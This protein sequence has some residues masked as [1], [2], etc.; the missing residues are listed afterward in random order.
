MRL[1][2]DASNLRSGGGITHIAELLQAARPQEHG[3][4]KV[5]VW[6]GGDTLRQLPSLPW[7]EQVYEPMLDKSLPARLY[8]QKMKLPHL[9][10][11]SCDCLFVPGGR[12]GGGFRP[13]VTMS[14]N[15]LPFESKEW[16]R[17]G[18]S[19]MAAKMFLL[20]F[21]QIRSL[22]NADGVIFL[23]EYARSVVCRT[24]RLK[25]DHP[26]IRHGVNRRFF[27][28]PREQKPIEQY[29]QSRPFKLLYVSKVEPYKHQWSIVEAVSKLRWGGLPISLELV[30]EPECPMAMQL[31]NQAIRKADPCH[32]FIQHLGYM[33]HSSLPDCYHNAD[34]FI[35]ASSCENLPN[36]LLEAMASGL[37]IACSNH[38]PMPE[39]LG[40]A[41]VYFDPEWPE[42]VAAAIQVLVE[43]S[44][45]RRFFADSAYER[46]QEYSWERCA[47]ETFAYLSTLAGRQPHS[48]REALQP[49]IV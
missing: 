8:W 9:A 28:S 7:L 37:P 3:I 21:S 12:T 42:Q 40:E 27:L 4:A 35:F 25:R 13:F 11:Q 39:I 18:F 22:R 36:I 38:G 26:V 48:Y 19:W 16:H 49:L 29:S 15:M 43:D 14:R 20:G 44:A 30:G 46:A 6:A 41:G 34:G 47:S 24:A 10:R 1:G 33:P 2:I 5:V 23:T 45:L 32:R 17:Y 31:L